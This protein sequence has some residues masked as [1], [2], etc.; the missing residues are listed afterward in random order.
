MVKRLSQWL[1]V[2][3]DEAGVA[4]DYQLQQTDRERVWERELKATTEGM[5]DRPAT[6]DDNEYA[7]RVENFA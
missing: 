7:P 3:N 5:T 4:A 6:D 1:I 2:W